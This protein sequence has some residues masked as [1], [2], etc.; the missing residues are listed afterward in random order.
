MRFYTLLFLSILFPLSGLSQISETPF[1]TAEVTVNLPIPD[2]SSSLK[3]SISI[4]GSGLPKELRVA[5]RIQHPSV[6]DLRI[7]LSHPTGQL[8]V[9]HNQ[10]PSTI[11][12][13]NPV[14]ETVTA[15]EVPLSL[16]YNSNAHGT[17]TLM[18][19][20]LVPGN[21][22]VLESWGIMMSPVSLL[23][24]PP[25]TPAPIQ[26]GLEFT[27]VDAQVLSASAS[28][29]E[30]TD[31]NEDDVTD[32]LIL[33]ET[34]N[35]VVIFTSNGT[36][37]NPPQ[38]LSVAAPK[39]VAV[40][41]LNG[42]G[43]RDIVAASASSS[44]TT[45][46]TIFIATPEGGYSTGFTTNLPTQLQHLAVLDINYDAIPDILVGGVPLW[47]QGNGDGSFQ[48]QEE[49]VY[50]G[51][52]FLSTADINKDGMKD[53]VVKINRGGTSQNNDPYVILLNESIPLPLF[54]ND[55]TQIALNGTFLQASSATTRIPGKN[56]IV[57]LSRSLESEP[58]QLFTIIQTDSS[59]LV[60]TIESRLAPNSILTPFSLF[61]MNGDGLDEFIFVSTTG[62]V[63][64]QKNP[65]TIGGSTK[66]LVNNTDIRMVC[67]G[68]FFEDGS[69]GLAAVTST[70]ELL[71]LQSNAG[72][73][74]VPPQLITPT[75]TPTS[76]LFITP[77][78]TPTQSAPVNTPTPVP[79]LQNNP[80]LNNDG[81]VDKLDLL[82]LIQSWGLVKP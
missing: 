52:E 6:Q 1:A 64:F 21:N 47:L 45:V 40:S 76:A 60:Q 80:D 79:P 62:I 41:D 25:P 50:L 33:S 48:P 78:V 65:E 71:L 39:Q 17:W 37:L 15:S 61:D 34:G 58:V 82:L 16:L 54:N 63:S 44:Q 73:R 55:G 49:F 30:C 22:G 36:T 31:I 12:P 67:A 42:D 24:V 2:G 11:N 32:I 66:A 81:K 57:I 43:L 69:V 5:L 70:N 53:I 72:A 18:I 14:Y 27:P 29:L 8:I 9:L 26:D 75:P 19:E 38:T 46:I 28:R 20:D 77:T 4:P 68:L 56:E 7:S 3:S 35:T 13:F 23:D 51:R 59:G 10:N 74:P